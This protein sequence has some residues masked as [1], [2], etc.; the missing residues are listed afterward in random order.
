MTP[1]KFYVRR[2]SDRNAAGFAFVGPLAAAQAEK[3]RASWAEADDK[4]APTLVPADAANRALV[5]RWEKEIRTDDAWQV[6][7]F[8]GEQMTF[9]AYRLHHEGGK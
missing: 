3:E 2:V 9:A 5:R 8:Q 1:T 4:Y 7:T 6:V